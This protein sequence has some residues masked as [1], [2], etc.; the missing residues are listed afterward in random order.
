MVRSACGNCSKTERRK[1]LIDVQTGRAQILLA[2]EG[3]SRGMDIKGLTHVFNVELPL[4]A[5]GYVHRAGRVGRT[6]SIANVVRH[7]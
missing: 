1:A 2:T 3:S 5:T 7:A 6:G 4:S